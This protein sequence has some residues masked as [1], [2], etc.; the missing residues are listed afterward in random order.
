ML[1]HLGKYRSLFPKIALVLHLAEGGVGQIGKRCAVRAK[2]WTMLLERHARRM[3]HTATNRVLQSAGSLANKIKAAKL[4][5][6]FTRSDVMLKQ[7][8][9]LRTADEVR[10]ALDVLVD[11]NWLKSV[12]DKST[13]GRP[14]QR[15]LINAKLSAE[16]ADAA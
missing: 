12:E 13:G 6:G 14:T 7:W 4:K 3:Y 8:A 2:A 10:S 15:Y 1:A 16:G 9:S 11:L 5:D